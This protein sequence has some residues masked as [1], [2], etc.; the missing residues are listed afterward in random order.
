M[1]KKK[2]EGHS[3]FQC[4]AGLSYRHR[5]FPPGQTQFPNLFAHW[6]IPMRFVCAPFILSQ[7]ENS[8]LMLRVVIIKFILSAMAV[9]PLASFAK[10]LCCLLRA[11]GN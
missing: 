8:A 5:G 1:E 3:L 11:P 2:T 9:T 10:T 7:K 6:Y 4:E